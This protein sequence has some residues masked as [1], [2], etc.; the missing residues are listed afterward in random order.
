[1]STT[2][3]GAEEWRRYVRELFADPDSLEADDQ[4]RA[5]TDDPDDATLKRYVR[6]LFS[7]PDTDNN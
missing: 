7:D 3:D 6:K 5:S 2:D 4:N 1:M